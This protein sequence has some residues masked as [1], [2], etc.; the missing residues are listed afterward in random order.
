MPFGNIIGDSMRSALTGLRR[1]PILVVPAE[2]GTDM[3]KNGFAKIVAVL[4]PALF[5]FV[6]PMD[7]AL[8]WL[9]FQR[10]QVRSAVSAH[11]RSCA[12]TKNFVL[13]EFTP[14]ETRTLLRWEHPR[15]FEYNLQ[16]YDIVETW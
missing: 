6:G 7:G 11:I 13:L 9:S 16:M 10:M 15:E 5:F 12:G 2:N 1:R 8:A 14:D 4:L 3:P